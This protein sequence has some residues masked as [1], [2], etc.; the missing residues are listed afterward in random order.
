MYLALFGLYL[1]AVPVIFL[2]RRGW[3]GRDRDLATLALIA[4]IV[5]TVILGIQAFA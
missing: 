3:T 5:A 4:M 1:I 2:R